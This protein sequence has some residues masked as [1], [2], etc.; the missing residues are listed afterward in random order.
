MAIDAQ[1]KTYFLMAGMAKHSIIRCQDLSIGYQNKKKAAVIA[2]GIDFSIT[3]GTLVSLV[4]SNGIGKSTLLKSLTAMLPTLSG[5]L[6]VDGIEIKDYSPLALATKL[7]VVLT[8]APTSKSLTVL[9][10]V[11]LG[12]Q[13][14]TNWM[15][16]LSQNDKEI[17]YQAL[18]DTDLADLKNK[19]CFELS[20]GQ[21]QRVYIARALAQ[22]TPLIVLD[23]PTTHLDLYHRASVVTLLKRLTQEKNKTILFSTHEIDLAIDISDK[24]LVM[25]PQKIIFD[26]PH[27]LIE[28]GSFNLLFPNDVVVFDKK[29]GRFSVS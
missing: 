1:K 6:Q 27:N 23:E 7:S 20:D 29:T 28:Q 9:E 12:R 15:G 10:L 19:N 2:S 17:I 26:S 11:S 5:S 3:Q 22:D 14:H 21:L 24:M 18:E 25:T 4:G 16:S 8:Q 13:P